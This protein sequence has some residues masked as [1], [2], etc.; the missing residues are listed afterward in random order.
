MRPLR[1]RQRGIVKVL[2]GYAA[3]PRLHPPEIGQQQIPGLLVRLGA[4]RFFQ[5]A[6]GRLSLPFP[7]RDLPLDLAAQ[8]LI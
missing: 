6:L 1:V 7:S 3:I 2:D 4:V 5:S 8:I